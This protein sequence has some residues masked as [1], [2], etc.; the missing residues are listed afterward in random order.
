MRAQLERT[1]GCEVFNRYGSREIGDM[2][3]ECGHEP[4]L[5][6]LPWCCHIEVLDDDNRPAPP[7]VDGDLVVTG[8]TNRAMPLLRY[9][10]GDRGVLAPPGT[11][12]CGRP[13]PRLAAVTGRTVDTFVTTSGV[14][15]AGGFFIQLVASRPWVRQFQAVQTSPTDVV[16]RVV[17]RG[18]MPADD[19]DDIVIGTRS[20]LGP[21]CRVSFQRV[22][23]IEATPSGKRHFTMRTF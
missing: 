1:F 15:V 19:L 21:D 23:A 7:G 13:G 17:V 2:A 20:V 6:V 16:F 22:R 12:T 8:L 9:R 18:P 5:H 4:G 10:I 3:G 14:K 11:C